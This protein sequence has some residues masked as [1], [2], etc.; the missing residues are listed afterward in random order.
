MQPWYYLQS[1][2]GQQ[3]QVN[4]V[5]NVFQDHGFLSALSFLQF[6]N[7]GACLGVHCVS[8]CVCERK[9]REREREFSLLKDKFPNY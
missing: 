6:F 2:L 5:F 9:G 1:C 7:C 3:M 4:I 8:V